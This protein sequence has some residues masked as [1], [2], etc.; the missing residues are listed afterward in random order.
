VRKAWAFTK[1]SPLHNHNQ[2]TRRRGLCR[3]RQLYWKN[4]SASVVVTP[5]SE[6]DESQLAGFAPTTQPRVSSWPRLVVRYV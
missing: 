3:H 4:A 2:R 5:P 6:A 1:P